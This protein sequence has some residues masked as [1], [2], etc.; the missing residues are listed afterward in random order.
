MKLVHWKRF[1]WDL[2][3]L[4]E[5]EP[6][7]PSY[8]TV[9]A[10]GKDEEKI[11]RQVILTA[12]GLDAAWGDAVNSVS[13]FVESQLATSFLQRAVP[14][15]VITH[16]V[17]IIAASALT[18]NDDATSHLISGPCVLSEY[19]NRGLGTA[20]LHESLQYLKTAGLSHAVAISKGNVPAGK[21]V[22]KKFGSTSEDFDFDAAL[23]AM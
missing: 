10:A 1:T 13:G 2:S 3:K 5:E 4:P 14:C 16:G 15:L 8:Y 12:F 17:R 9:R 20:L 18:T 11:V 6:G 23:A 19:R 21:F 22:Y 7:L